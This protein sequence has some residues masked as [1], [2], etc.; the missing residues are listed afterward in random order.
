L[1]LHP[2]REFIRAE[3]AAGN[4]DHTNTIMACGIRAEESP[5]RAAMGIY[6]EMDEYFKLPQWRP[7]HQWT[8]QQ[9]FD[10]H[11]KYNVE[12]NP[13]YKEGMR[14]VGCMPCVMSSHGE[15]AEIAAR[16]PD[17]FEKVA[18]AEVAL[19]EVSD[20][21][22]FWGHGDIPE[23]FCSRVWRH[24]KTGV[25]YRIPTAEDVRRYV[26]LTKSQKKH[27]CSEQLFEE[28][29]KAETWGV[30]SSIYGLCE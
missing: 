27:G 28:F 26:Q 23:R 17:V 4:I 15:L 1:K 22:S 10:I 18:Q 6:V 13:L 9:V 8:W 2:I 16:L 30:C 20:H 19:A 3:I 24:P 5:K 14:R 25:E 29:D 21:S 11:K 12:P 7:L